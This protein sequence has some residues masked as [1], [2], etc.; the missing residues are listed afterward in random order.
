MRAEMERE[1]AL[2]EYSRRKYLELLRVLLFQI[3]SYESGHLDTQINHTLYPK[4]GSP[5]FTGAPLYR[6]FG[7]FI[8]HNSLIFPVS[9]AP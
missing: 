8:S 6:I 4:Q 9:V 7:Y 1:G 5:S 3:E 2:D